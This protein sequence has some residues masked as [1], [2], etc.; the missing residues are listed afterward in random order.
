MYSSIKNKTGKQ[1]L[2]KIVTAAF[3]LFVVSQLLANNKHIVAAANTSALESTSQSDAVAIAIVTKYHISTPNA[4]PLQKIA[5]DYVR[6]AVK[7]NGNIMAEAYNETSDAAAL[8]LI[9]RWTSESAYEANKQSQAAQALVNAANTFT[10]SAEVIAVR[11]LEPI[12]K[13]AWRKT[14]NQSDSPFTAMLFVSAQPGTQNVFADRY[15]IAMPKFRGEPGVVTYQL[16]QMVGDDTKFFTYEKFR[17]ENALQAHLVFPPTQPILDYLHTSITNPPFENGL[18]KLV[19]F[20]PYS[21][22]NSTSKK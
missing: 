9:E 17:N 8:W 19:Q 7:A 18:H 13:Q 3:V 16:S 10:D 1:W 14:P 20:A 21:N 4:Q 11:D 12:S 15:H 22:A 2:A 5:S 6:D